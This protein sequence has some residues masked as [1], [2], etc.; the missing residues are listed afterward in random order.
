[1]TLTATEP[2]SDTPGLPGRV[3]A[4]LSAGYLG[5]STL[6][7]LLNTLLVFFYL[8][9]ASSGLPTLV[10]DATILGVLNVVAIVA[11]TGRFTDAI[12]DPLIAAWS[13]RSQHRRGRRIPFM[14][15]G[16]IPAAVATWLMFVPPVNEISGWNIAWVLGVQTVLYIALTAYVTPAFALVADLGRTPLERLR[17]STW[18]S[19]AWAFG[20]VLA[21]STLFTAGLLE[22]SLGTFRAWQ[23][24][25]GITALMGLVFMAVPVFTL[26]EPRWTN[27]YRPSTMPL[28]PAVRFVLGNPFFRFYAAADFAYFGGLAIIQ[29]GLLFYITVL[30][31]LE[32]WVSTVLLLVMVVV[33]L[34][35]FPVV[36]AWGRKLHGGKRPTVI[37]FCIG[38]AVFA[39][40]AGLGIFDR[41]LFGQVVVPIVVFAI[42]F[43]ILS[44]MP[45]WILAD[46]AEHSSLRTGESQA[47]M[48]YATRT[49]LQKLATT[50]G[51]VTLALLLQL[52]RDVGDDLG[53]RL[54]GVAGAV[55]YL[56]A[57]W[58]F[59]RYDEHKLQHELALAQA[60]R[61]AADAEALG[62]PT[63]R[64]AD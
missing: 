4:G 42:P 6:I 26:D 9:P 51:V 46:I 27:S 33:S 40:I 61:A 13:D 45:Q 53:V 48:F 20:L 32:E 49:F 8:P 39:T 59:S 38:A 63:D 3:V 55:L 15:L 17:L 29:T 64:A 2:E 25:A 54:T 56:L 57:A 34:F 10:T 22:E 31:E 1:M 21:A 7:N 58:F 35:L 12:T 5:M 24:A 37:A 18:T 14:A 30:V 41:F 19:L 60:E 28:L 23:T 16:M 36:S 47:A 11:A 50:M 52:G 62:G 44:I 43:A